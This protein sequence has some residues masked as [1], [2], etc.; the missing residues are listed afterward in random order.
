MRKRDHNVVTNAASL[1]I[2]GLLAGVVVAAA[3][4][5][6]IA[7]SGL[8]A[9]AGADT[10]DKLP[11]E[12]TVTRSPQMSYLYASDGKTL[13]A[14]MYDE[15]RRDIPLADVPQVMRDA[16]IAAE[17]KNFFKH[18]GVDIK[19][20]VRAFVAN[21]Q[22]G[23][24]QQGASTLTMQYV[25]LAIEYS[26][27]HP[28]DV[29][30]AT[31]DTPAR[32]LREIRYAMAVE[33]KLSKDEILERYL[34]IAFF[35]N[36]AFG[37]F[38]ASQVYFGKQPR[39]LKPEEAAFLAGLVKFPGDYAKDNPQG[40]KR[41]LDRGKYVLDQMVVTRALTRQ[42][43]DAA[44][45][46]P[47]DIRVKRAP[48][49]CVATIK[50]SWGFFCDFFYRWWLSQETFGDTV[51]ERERRLKSGGYNIITTL[52]VATQDAAKKNVEKNLPTY[53]KGSKKPEPHALM[54][55]AV[56]PGSGYVR[57]IAT[58]RN[59][60]LDDLAH[61]ANGPA[62]NPAK[63]KAG[64]RGTYP[65]TTN[66]LITGGGDI[67]GYQ[68]GSTFKVFT[69]V[70]AL[71]NGYPLAYT[72]NAKPVYKSNYIVEYDSDS[73]CPGTNKYCPVNA[74]KSMTGVHN[75]WG[76]FGRSVNTFFVPLEERVGAEKAVD[77]AKRL[78]VRFLAHGT[79]DNPNDY[80]RSQDSWLAHGWGAFTLGVSS[81][82]PL[83]L[84]N[85]Y[86]TLAADGKYCEP[87]P[88][89]QIVDHTG[90]KLDVAN[91]RC[92]QAVKT[93]V[94]RAA[95]DAARCPVG[96]RSDTSRCE[97]AT[98]G[99]TKGIVNKPVAGKS[100]TTDGS[101]TAALVAMTKQIAVAGII[102]DPDWAQT[103]FNF[104]HDEV[105][106]TVM[107]TLRDAMK[108]KKG[109]QFTPPDDAKL[110]SGDQRSIPD[111]TCKSVG[112]ARSILERA[113]FV[114]EVNDTKIGSPCP[115]GTVAET[116]PS[117]RTI[118][119]GVV[120]LRLSDGKGAL[121]PTPPPRKGGGHGRLCP[122]IC[123]N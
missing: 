72:I 80:E 38:A 118:K 5:P 90:A 23:E 75:M 111:V 116:E 42:Q 18:N 19:G 31:E 35:G 32:K 67:T 51:Y 88:V 46:T 37:V 121:P 89:Q 44:K 26:A 109:I 82:I 54:V 115:D 66:P 10:F 53:M 57:A 113:G 104:T 83:D 70:A 71:E 95:I 103:T 55:A 84:A 34:N 20:V 119:G 69:L 9:K 108:G 12:L 2:C 73:A 17:D 43:A 117:G 21:K 13:L 78:G 105:N 64:I 47:L 58:N 8:A 22:A 11:S 52:D 87:I 99:A 3:A 50:N 65:N 77:V 63:R 36:G 74:N 96:D 48:N 45:A 102:A 1:T 100:G 24:T 112:D 79:K 49:D 27:T 114:V 41:A 120:M 101:R 123:I 28:R 16:I 6:A 98:A 7:M 14:M 59:F 68:A 81:T 85:A 110:I 93:Q 62:T 97:G 30:A 94:A 39:D 76:A 15:N 4:F 61:P 107:Y 40:I 122:P 25:R 29:V 60:K 86:A 56:E 33:K 106:P 91:P 92:H